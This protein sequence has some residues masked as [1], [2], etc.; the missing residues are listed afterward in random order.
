MNQVILVGRLTS[1][2]KIKEVENGKKKTIITLAAQRPFKNENGIYETD[3]IE[4]VLWNGVAA[5]TQEYCHKGD[6]VGIKGRLQNRKYEEADEAKI[7]TEVIA[8]KVT[9]L[10]SNK[11]IRKEEV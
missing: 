11:E 3:F 1:D 5:S 7:V 2:P 10:S 8:D 4:C 6:V 9:F